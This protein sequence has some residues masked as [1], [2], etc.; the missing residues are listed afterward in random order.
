[1][2][3]SEWHVQQNSGCRKNLAELDE[4]KLIILKTFEKSV[5]IDSLS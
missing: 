5:A 1:M 3:I 4:A 2:T